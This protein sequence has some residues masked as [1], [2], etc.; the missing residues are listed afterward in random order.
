MNAQL[1]YVVGPSGAGKDSLL[2][3]LRAQL[4]PSLPLHWARRTIN[5]PSTPQGERHESVSAIE[6]EHLLATDQLA[7]HWQ[8]NAHC[9]GIR[10]TELAPLAQ[11]QWLFV[12]GSRAHLP[13]V[14]LSHPGLT[15]LHITA[16]TQVL[17]QRLV[18]RERESPEAIEQRL[19]RSIDL[20][21]PAGCRLIEIH[22]HDS[23]EVS[24]QQLLRALRA[25]AD[26][27]EP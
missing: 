7:M 26:W 27:P 4:P 23:L 5:R 1:I 6:F 25:L 13:Q 16:D 8:A 24:G 20:Q 18:Q 2:N 10:H 22:N 19:D 14:A 15:V 9:Y 12:N 17:R 3:W 11:G 21:L